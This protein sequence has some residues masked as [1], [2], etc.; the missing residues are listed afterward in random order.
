MPSNQGSYRA[1]SVDDAHSSRHWVLDRMR[2]C[3]WAIPD[4]CERES[5]LVVTNSS[6]IETCFPSAPTTPGTN[7]FAAFCAFNEAEIAGG[8]VERDKAEETVDN[9]ET[10]AT[11]REAVENPLDGWQGWLNA[12]TIFS[13]YLP[14]SVFRSLGLD[15]MPRTHFLLLDFTFEESGSQYAHIESAVQHIGFLTY[16]SVLKTP[17]WSA[18]E[19]RAA[20]KRIFA[21]VQEQVTK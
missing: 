5:P 12:H 8:R 7:S 19:L 9:G 13:S 3:D 17:K 21:N 10:L 11:L 4:Q 6:A 2:Q 18:S 14:R 15:G 20:L 1:V 16:A